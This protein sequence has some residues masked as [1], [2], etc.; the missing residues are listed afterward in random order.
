MIIRIKSA[1]P[2][3]I[4]IFTI[5]QAYTQDSYYNTS[6]I[7]NDNA[8]YNENIKTVLLYK[9][10][11]ELSPPIIQLHSGEKLV[12]AFDDLDDQYKQY[13]Y[14]VVHCDAFWNKSD[15]LQIEYI[16]GFTDGFI[17]DYKY[18]F[19]TTVPYINYFLEFPTE[20]MRLKKSG[21]YIIKVF[22]DSDDDEN[23][24]LTHRFMI[25]EPLVTVQG[26]VGNSVDLDLRYTH[27]QVNFKIFPEN[28]RLTDSHSNLH[29]FVMQNGRW[30]NIIKNVQPRM[31]TGNEFDYSL[32]NELVFAAGN[33]YRYLDMKTL[34]YN[35]DR[36][37]SL[38]YTNEGYQ[39]YIMTDL[40]R[41]K[42]N[43][44][45]LEDINGRKLIA[46]ND[47]RDP[48]TEGDYA[49]VHFL[50]PYNYPLIE[51]NLYVFG[52]LSDWQFNPGNQMRYN[53]DIKA[54]EAS[55][56]LKQ[57]YY[58]YEYAFLENHSQVG[59]VTFI[60]GSYWETRN[61]YTVFV[62]HRQQGE[63]Y[64]RMIGMGFVESAGQ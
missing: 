9:S 40:P 58:N 64:D 37:Q 41:N 20:D 60:E 30:D 32:V 10:G 1:I 48:Y 51:G 34:K 15:L 47:T 17:E 19:N 12:L 35:T 31:I 39:V 46:A 24:V 2:I 54:Y 21:N 63:T 8:V 26:R 56:L 61:E 25:Y 38:Q 28:F 42:G 33:E 23:V 36:M 13:R 18:S 53:Y 57:G 52:A 55:I 11:F 43:Y 3:I 14:T 49:W 7:R 29:V 22:V 6:F 27:H 59:D 45:Y 62:Y 5:L 50:L 16:D 4:F 44:F